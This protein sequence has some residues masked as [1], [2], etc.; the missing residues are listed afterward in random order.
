MT[1]ANISYSKQRLGIPEENTSFDSILEDYHQEA[2]R[3]V[4]S[5]ERG[6]GIGDEDKKY[7]ETNYVCYLFRTR[8]A[9]MFTTSPEEGKIFLEQAKEILSGAISEE[10]EDEDISY[11]LDL[12]E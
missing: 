6:I 3:W 4:D 2:Q 1:Y 7:A 9:Q 8:N 5:Q 10:E 12:T 11:F